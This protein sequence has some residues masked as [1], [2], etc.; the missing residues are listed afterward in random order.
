M[1]AVVLYKDLNM[2]SLISLIGGLVLA[3]GLLSATPVCGV[4]DTPDLACIYTNFGAGQS[5]ISNFGL[6]PGYTAIGVA[7]TPSASYLLMDIEVAAYRANA[8]TADS[9]QFSIYD[10]SGGFPGAILET[11]SLTGLGI[12]DDAQTATISA[13]SV[14][15]P[16]LTAGMQYWVVMH[17]INPGDVTWN[18]NST[19]QFGPATFNAPTE[20][21][22][23]FWSLLPNHLQGALAVDGE[24]VAPE[25]GTLWLC[26]PLAG[27]LFF[28]RRRRR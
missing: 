16:L 5:Y 27:S 18:A 9:V 14:L 4:P 13:A 2:K 1:N 26:A 24:Q 20:N 21:D 28:F 22:P 3:S 19:S 25:P 8:Q 17:G 12:A 23:A 6:T 15:H 11:F 10:S 7:F